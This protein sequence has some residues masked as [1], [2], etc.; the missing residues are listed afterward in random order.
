MARPDG[1][2]FQLMADEVCHDILRRLL[3]SVAPLTQKALTA[4]SPYDSSTISRRMGDLEDLGLVQRPSAH[5]PYHLQ[6]RE[7]TRALLR[8][9]AELARLAHAAA[10]ADLEADI[11]NLDNGSAS[12]PAAR[13]VG[14][15][16]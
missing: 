9:G 16:S 5:A 11:A 14:S 1:K 7:Q 2:L 8:A 6:F 15:A 4:A 12:T 3:A 10:A 13:R